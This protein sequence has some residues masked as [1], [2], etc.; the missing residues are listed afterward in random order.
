MPSTDP[1]PKERRAPITNLRQGYRAP[2]EN[3]HVILFHLETDRHLAKPP[4]HRHEIMELG[5]EVVLE[6]GRPRALEIEI[7]PPPH[8]RGGD[9]VQLVAVRSV[10][11]DAGD[12][13]HPHPAKRVRA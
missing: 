4:A 12:V 1:S 11:N 6:H 3:G 7:G 10:L 13:R 8:L 2:L 5:I 9:R